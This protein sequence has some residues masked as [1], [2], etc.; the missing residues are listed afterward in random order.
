[1]EKKVLELTTHN[2]FL[3]KER[4]QSKVKISK[5]ERR[6]NQLD[7]NMKQR[8]SAKLKIK[9]KLEEITERLRV[10]EE[11]NLELHNVIS[12]INH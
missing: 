4:Q 9:Q 10:T 11:K 12:K 7:V 8:E 3:F 2:E 1:M 6:N 5:L